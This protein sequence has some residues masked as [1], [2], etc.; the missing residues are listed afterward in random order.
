[1]L[2][3]TRRNALL[4]A[5]VAGAAFG[6]QAP[7]EPTCDVRF[8]SRDLWPGGCDKALNHVGLF[9]SYLT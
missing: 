2:T 6:L 4:T 8:R 1:M 5:A 7:M 9:R 3:L